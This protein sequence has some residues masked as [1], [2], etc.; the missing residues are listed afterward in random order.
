MFACTYVFMSICVCV[1][2]Y[3]LVSRPATG[4]EWTCISKCIYTNTHTH[5]HSPGLSFPL[6]VVVLGM[7]V[8]SLYIN[9]HIY[10]YTHPRTCTPT[11]I[12]LPPLLVVL[13][14]MDIISMCRNI[15]VCKYIPIHTHT[16][17]YIY[18]CVYIYIYKHTIL[19]QNKSM[20]R[21]SKTHQD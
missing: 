6:R 19:K 10:Q 7:Y 4:Y 5:P 13:V 20:Y 2:T 21:L 9:M 14:G 18:M 8:A 3:F 12:E 1:N 15:H 17:I 16:R 11:R